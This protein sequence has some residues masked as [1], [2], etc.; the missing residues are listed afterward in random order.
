[1]S[2]RWEVLTP[3]DSGLL[4]DL[5]VEN[6]LILQL[7][8][9]RGFNDK[10][11]I[12]EFL[13]PD[14]DNQILDPF[15][16]EDMSKATSRICEA[17]RDN[18]KI[19]IYGDYD[20]DGVCST[21]VLYI[22]IKKLGGQ[23]DIRIPFREGEGYGL[24]L[25]AAQEIINNGFQLVITVDCG[26]SN[27]EEVAFFKKNKVAVIITDHHQEP[28]ELPIEALAI[29]NPSLKDS[30]YPFK[31]L[32]GAGVAFKVVQGLMKTQDNF[33]LLGKIPVGF[34]KWLLDLVAIATVGDIMPL[35]GEN[36]LFVKYGLLVLDKTR[37]KGVIKIIE[38]VN[39]FSGQLDSQYIGWRLVP[40]LNAAGRINHAA[41]AFELLISDSD[42]ESDKLVDQLEA[43]NSKR[44]SITVT[45]LKE[46]DHIISQIKDD[47]LLLAVG[48][49]WHP[50]VVGLVAGRIS[51]KYNLPAIVISQAGEKFVGSG[52]SIEGFDITSALSQCS[53]YLE[54]FGGHPQAC[55]FTIV[56]QD[57]LEKF[58]QKIVAIATASL[59]DA[60][61]RPVLKIEAEIEL[62]EINWEFYN[63][64][65][66][67]EPYG[68]GNDKP[69]F[70]VK[71][72]IIE[73]IQA[74]GVDGKHLRAM[75]SQINHQVVH[76]IIGFSFGDWCAELKVGDSIDVVFE[77]GIN[78][79]N[80]H[81]DLQLKVI[82]LMRSEV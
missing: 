41:L 57:N 36:R 44:Q 81:K 27:K 22:A 60:D 69:L 64:L 78:K 39:H 18:E 72:L 47:K 45:M 49:S 4:S 34:D 2:K 82:D 62:A 76:K 59:K 37:R 43:E 70:L 15:L 52:R 53:D 80:G 56:G 30:K 40:R 28:Q 20:A 17:I 6:R 21:A 65:E 73:Q 51:D 23:V 8:Y 7:L 26:I 1:M 16:F 50:G 79:W 19:L 75:V 33:D 77:L 68:E 10:K 58:S 32:C 35:L 42:E 3:M 25:T 9:N 74:V 54:K 24:N 5:P 12:D 14:Y 38:K 46:A 11:S 48:A 67:F 71:K 61:L 66:K 55:G 29:I 31:K 63:Q 13:N